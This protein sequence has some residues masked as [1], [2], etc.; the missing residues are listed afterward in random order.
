MLATVLSATLVGVEGR[1][2]SVEVHVSPG[3]PCFSIVGLPDASCREARDRV[4]AAIVSSGLAWPQRR[5][6]VNLA[7]SS[8][9]KG[10]A[11]LDLPIAAALLAADGQLPTEA[12]GGLAFLGE[13]GLDGSLRAIPGTLPLVDALPAATVVVPP[14]CVPEARLVER[15]RVRAAAS[16]RSVVAVLRGEGEWPAIAL[17]ELPPPGRDGPDLSEVRGQALGRKALEVSA[18]GGHHLL[19]TGPPGSGKTML[20][21]RLPGILPDLTTAEALEVTRVY[22]AA[23]LA[24]PAGGLVRRP[25]FR[26]PH[27]SAS[28][29]S[30]IGGGTSRMR[31]GEI[32]CAHR[33]VL[34]LDEVAEFSA[35]VLD[36]LRQ[37]LEEGT[38]L[39][40]RARASVVFPAR[41]LLVAAM[42]P[43]PCGG[44]GAPGS[45]RCSDSARE[46]YLS[47]VSGPL[48]DRFD[49]RVS[50]D[51][52]DVSELLACAGASPADG[53]DSRHSSTEVAK[54]VAAARERARRRGVCANADLPAS[55]LE[56][57]VPLEREARRLL[58]VRL[59]QGRLSARGLHRVRRL[60]RTVADLGGREGPVGAD[61][62]HTALALRGD[63]WEAGG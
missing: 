1:P 31:P 54:R 46:R 63:P 13:L 29:V 58:E 53:V 19:L 25:P 49:I 37:P 48:L 45:C 26:A 41:F 11:G 20:A 34:F 62:V 18:A 50:I 16:L 39:V 61:D 5:V 14:A 32:S 17:P 30:L 33:G 4:R 15:H 36:T 3:V 9:R 40:C 47:R 59:R 57:T 27:H 24:L 38:V 7:P 56:D 22:S 44:G 21:Q 8:L 2:I 6:T 52:P 51:R 23:G 35:D 55:T 42:N 10:G 60:A 12:L 28:A 43:C